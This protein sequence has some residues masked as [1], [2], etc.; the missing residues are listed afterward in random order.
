MY[1][2][3][4]KSCPISRNIPDMF[5][6]ASYASTPDRVP[7]AI[8][9]CRLDH[10]RKFNGIAHS[11][12]H[13][14]LQL[15]LTSRPEKIARDIVLAEVTSLTTSSYLCQGFLWMIQL[16]RAWTRKKHE[17]NQTSATLSLKI[18]QQLPPRQCINWNLPWDIPISRCLIEPNLVERH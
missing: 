6:F 9:K 7:K 13:S 5:W 15:A 14:G 17:A 18:M 16:L 1:F 10:D 8:W 2:Q 11:Q 3:L 12:V 4:N